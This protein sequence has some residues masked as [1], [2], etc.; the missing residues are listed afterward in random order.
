VYD[1]DS[2]GVLPALTSVTDAQALAVIR[3]YYRDDP[4]GMESDQSISL[5]RGETLQQWAESL[6]DPLT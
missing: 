5:E 4:E 3:R 6:L 1:S 2:G